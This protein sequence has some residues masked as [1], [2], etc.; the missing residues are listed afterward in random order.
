MT[1][2]LSTILLSLLKSAGTVLS[3]STFKFIYFQIYPNLPV[4]I[5]YISTIIFQLVRSVFDA[6]VDVSL[7]VASLK[8]DF[9]A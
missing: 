1:T 9:V 4:L 2:S 6:S 8:S 3:L 7:L 5:L